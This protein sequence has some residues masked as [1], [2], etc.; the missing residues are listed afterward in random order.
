[1]A[2]LLDAGLVEWQVDYGSLGV[3]DRLLA[4]EARRK[5]FEQA[6]AGQ[7]LDCCSGDL[8]AGIVVGEQYIG[9]IEIAMGHDYDYCMS[10]RLGDC[11]KD[12]SLGR[13]KEVEGGRMSVAHAH[14]HDF[15]RQLKGLAKVGV[16]AFVLLVRVR[17]VLKNGMSALQ[18]ASYKTSRSTYAGSASGLPEYLPLYAM[19][20]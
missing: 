13:Q 15:V 4:V 1:M 6:V 12:R 16:R 14:V 3:E 9:R 7:V 19:F 8:A 10:P 11:H 5:G 20:C 17:R 2:R 18:C